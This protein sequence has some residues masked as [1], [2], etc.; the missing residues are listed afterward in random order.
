MS[1][2]TRKSSEAQLNVEWNLTEGIEKFS[3]GHFHYAYGKRMTDGR[4]KD[5]KL[6]NK[7]I[8]ENSAQAC[9]DTIGAI[10]KMRTFNINPISAHLKFITPYE[11][12]VMITISDSDF[13]KER[14][15]TI[16]DQV[17]LIQDESKSDFYSI[18]FTFVN[19]SAKFDD[20]QLTLDGFF[21]SLKSLDRKNKAH[22]G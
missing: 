17:R 18:S 19:R 10:E 9:K 12:K 7:L 22:A 15:L 5:E 8:D 14:F 20:E 11:V 6:F 1:T 3:E 13:V 21:A 16:Y 4:Q 2:I